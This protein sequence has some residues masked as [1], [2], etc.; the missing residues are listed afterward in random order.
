MESKITV[1]NKGTAEAE[2]VIEETQITQRKISMKEVDA[3]LQ[4]L[5]EQRIYWQSVKDGAK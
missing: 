4:S 2:I 1:M 3:I 5:E